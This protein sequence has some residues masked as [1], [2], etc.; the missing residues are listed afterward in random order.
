MANSLEARAPFLDRAVL[1]YAASLPDDYKLHDRTTKVILRAAFAD[2]LP[3]EVNQAPKR[4]FGVP[5]DQWF[6]G[7]LRDYVRDTLLSSS[8]RSSQYLCRPFVQ[9]L[10]DAHLAGRANHG[11]KLWTLM[12]LERWLTLLPQWRAA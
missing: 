6:R 5:L 1:D 12:T 2:V 4:G 8:S 11:H 10:V 7:E 3:S 9:S